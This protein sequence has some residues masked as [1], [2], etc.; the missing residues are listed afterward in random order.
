MTAQWTCLSRAVSSVERNPCYRCDDYVARRLVPGF[1]AIPGIGKLFIRLLAA[2]GAYEWVIAR[3]KYIDA[4][5]K[6]CLSNAFT[7][8]VI[9]GAG[10]DTRALRF[11]AEAQ[12]ATFYELDAAV[13]QEAK[14][15]Q[16][17]NRH[18]PLPSNL[19]F[20]PIDFDK[21]SPGLKLE[22]AGFQRNA[23]TLFL[24]EGVLQYLQPHSVDQNFKLICELSGAG[25]QVVFDCIY[26]S[27]LRRENRYYGERGFSRQVSGEGEQW[28]FGIEEGELEHFVSTHGCRL[29]DYK[30][31]TALEE[32][33]F[34]DAAGKIVGRVNGT[35]FLATA[36]VIKA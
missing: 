31:A 5:M 25:S 23:R 10:F 30:D 6:D 3:T 19:L 36:L 16:Y 11:Q 33:Y 21:E 28:H 2:R 1:F 7:Q 26:A 22:Q 32:M 24:L 4:V 14:I 13:T 18:L 27:V 29:L 34:K 20:I 8:V 9:L 35:H 17:K 12:K 15:G